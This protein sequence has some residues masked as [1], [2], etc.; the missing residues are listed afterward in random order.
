[1]INFAKASEATVGPTDTDNDNG[2]PSDSPRNSGASTI[3]HQV[4]RVASLDIPSDSPHDHDHEMPD[5][6]RDNQQTTQNRMAIDFIL[7]RDLPCHNGFSEASATNG[8][9]IAHVHQG[10]ST[11][12]TGEKT[13]AAVQSKLPTSLIRFAQP[14]DH[15]GVTCQ[16]GRWKPSTSSSRNPGDTSR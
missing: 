9:S 7:N 2:D 10:G 13:I 16:A 4:A 1:M 15:V 11:T 8:D 12:G 14:T 5:V 6:Q 3:Q